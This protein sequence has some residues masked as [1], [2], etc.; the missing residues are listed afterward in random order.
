MYE[1]AAIE[2]GFN[3]RHLLTQPPVRAKEKARQRPRLDSSKI[4]FRTPEQQIGGVK[5]TFSGKWIVNGS[6]G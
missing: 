2:F 6:N 5:R 1:N 3:I 4:C